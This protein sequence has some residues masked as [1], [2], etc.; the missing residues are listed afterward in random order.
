MERLRMY[1]SAQ[2]LITI[3]SSS[4]TGVDPEIRTMATP[5]L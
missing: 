4:F 1:I 3:K 2:N 5:F